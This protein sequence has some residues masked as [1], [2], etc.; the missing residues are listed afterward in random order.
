MAAWREQQVNELVELCEQLR[1]HMEDLL[2]ARVVP[3]EDA[4]DL[5]K[6]YWALVDW[7]LSARK[8]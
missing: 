7:V 6:Q 4:N 3:A 8:K 5:R 2:D 1:V